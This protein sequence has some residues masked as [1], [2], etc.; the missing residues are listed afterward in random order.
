MSAN[1]PEI[2]IADASKLSLRPLS[3][4]EK[5]AYFVLVTAAVNAAMNLSNYCSVIGKSNVAEIL[6]DTIAKPLSALL[7]DIYAEKNAAN[8]DATGQN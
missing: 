5:Y 3:E 1:L 6:D 4:S 8:V 2:N 7:V